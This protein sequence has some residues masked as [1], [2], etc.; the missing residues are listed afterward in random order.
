MRLFYF[1]IPKERADLLDSFPRWSFVLKKREF[2]GHWDVKVMADPRLI[3][4]SRAYLAKG[5]EQW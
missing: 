1:R 3:S 4:N 2:D 5:E